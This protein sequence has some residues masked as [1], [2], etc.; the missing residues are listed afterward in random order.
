MW[1]G[2]HNGRDRRK[3]LKGLPKRNMNHREIRIRTEDSYEE[4]VCLWPPHMEL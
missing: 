2:K 1:E 4:A 3:E